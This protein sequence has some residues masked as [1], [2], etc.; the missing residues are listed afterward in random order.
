MTTVAH[1]RKGREPRTAPDVKVVYIGRPSAYENNHFIE[2]TC[3]VCGVVH[4]RA[5]SIAAFRKDWYSALYAPLR[6]AALI[7]LKDAILLCWCKP[8]AC[9]GDVIAEFVNNHYANNQ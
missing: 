7:E 2:R 8:N 1:I 3:R 5:E 4:T 6:A 9:H